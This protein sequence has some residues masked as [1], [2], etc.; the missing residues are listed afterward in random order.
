MSR[1]PFVDLFALADLRKERVKALVFSEAR[2][3][4]GGWS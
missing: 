1:I 3:V 4:R 2:C